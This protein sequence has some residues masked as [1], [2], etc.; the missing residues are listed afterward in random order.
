[1][2]DL[3]IQ[4]S[5]IDQARKDREYIADCEQLGI[6]PLP[7]RYDH[8]SRDY[9]GAI[10][11]EP[12]PGLDRNL[13][14]DFIFF[15]DEPERTSIPG[16]KR[17]AFLSVLNTILPESPNLE[18]F[19]R[20]AG[21]RVLALSWMMGRTIHAT[22]SLAD[23]AD[24]LHISRAILSFH[25]RKIEDAT[26]LHGRQQKAT[27][28]PAVYRELRKQQ[29][30]GKPRKS[31]QAFVLAKREAFERLRQSRQLGSGTP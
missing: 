4:D 26:G 5:E 17:E 18:T 25:V 22:R 10:E 3:D 7:A 31:A 30:E 13:Q 29:T 2:H 8:A 6:E 11:R 24:E 9:S 23:L 19:V 12:A 16:E 14:P 28:T 1:M 21:F 15:D 20:T 27:S